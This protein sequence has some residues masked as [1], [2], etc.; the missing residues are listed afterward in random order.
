MNCIKYKAANPEGKKYCGDC[1]SLLSL[2]DIND[3]DLDQLI[4]KLVK[5]R[6]KDQK[7]VELELFETV[8]TRLSNWAKLFSFFVGIPVGLLLLVLGLLGIKTYSDFSGLVNTGKQDLT[9]RLDQ[10]QQQ[11]ET[12]KNKSDNLLT[13]YQ[14]L[15]RQLADV[16]ALNEKVGNLETAVG[17]IASKV[18]V[19]FE[20][21]AALTPELTKSLE[22]SLVSYIKYLNKIGFET[23]G[24]RVKISI[25]PKDDKN[26]YYELKNNRITIGP[27]AAKDQTISSRSQ[28]V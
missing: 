23:K 28:L 18:G 19:D 11:A 12:I 8:L 16:N 4:Q 22:S 27:S 26:S 1:G 7:V 14:V 9:Q 24:Q 15:E 21:S 3:S 25:D 5:D 10:A 6:F 13:Q 20:H 17:K 2:K